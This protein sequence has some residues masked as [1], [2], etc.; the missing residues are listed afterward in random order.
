VWREQAQGQ[1]GYTANTRQPQNQGGGD[2][3]E[4]QPAVRPLSR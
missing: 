3:N 2:Q 4:Q 1:L